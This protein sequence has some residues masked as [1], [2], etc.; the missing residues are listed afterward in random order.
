MRMPRKLDHGTRGFAFL[1]F[2]SAR[3]AD[4]AVSALRH[5]HL[6]GRHLVIERAAVA[7]DAEVSLH[8]DKQL[9]RME[10]ARRTLDDG[11]SL[12]RQRPT[13]LMV[14]NEIEERKGH[15]SPL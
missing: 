14:T 12:I 13:R 10:E 4:V 2:A 15:S 1:E 5:T 3:E 11:S 7:G 6:L 8:S 9:K